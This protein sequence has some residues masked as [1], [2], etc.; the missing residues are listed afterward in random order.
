MRNIIEEIR[1]IRRAK[2]ET[3]KRIDS[4][5]WEHYG[6]IIVPCLGNQ[7]L[8]HGEDGLP[9]RDKN[10]CSVWDETEWMAFKVFYKEKQIF[11]LT[12]EEASSLA[13]FI[14]EMIANK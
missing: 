6:L 14:Q 9:E 4:L 2:K 13:S 10:D 8:K 5:K 11:T 1:A 12:E 7:R 3:Q